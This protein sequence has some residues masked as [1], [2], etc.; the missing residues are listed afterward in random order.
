[1]NKKEGENPVMKLLIYVISD[2]LGDT[3]EQVVRA[4]MAQ[5]TSDYEI[6]KYP[7]VQSEAMIR[8]IF[9]SFAT[10][11]IILVHTIVNKGLNCYLKEQ[12]Q[13]LGI[14]NVDLMSNMINAIEAETNLKAKEEPGIIRK[15]DQ[16]YFKRIAAIEFAVKYDDG[17]D[18]SALKRADV[19]IV[20]ISRTSKTPLSMYLANKNIKVM[21][22]PLV[23]EV[24]VPKELYQVE[25]ARIIGLVNSAEK[26]NEIRT[27][28]L[29]SL[30]VSQKSNYAS[31]ARILEEL[32]YAQGIMRKLGCPVIDVSTKAIEETADII[33]GILKKHDV[34][35]KN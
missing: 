25:K 5:F 28:R 30:G 23:P 7:N 12:A 11:R 14:K 31:M 24:P 9:E 8:E 1:M 26:L 20:G 3:A 29:K 13:Q 22:I 35:I 10:K 34:D 33:F 15:L 4:S 6:V 19:V 21:N 18:V 27:E 16:D 2:S 32:D 17:K